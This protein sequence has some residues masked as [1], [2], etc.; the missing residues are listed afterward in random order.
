MIWE[1]FGGW[2]NNDPQWLLRYRDEKGQIAGETGLSED[3]LDRIIELFVQK[4][5]LR[6]N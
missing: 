6:I 1:S 2:F 5:I 3:Q 4:D